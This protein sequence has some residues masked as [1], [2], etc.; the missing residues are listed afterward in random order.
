[1]ASVGRTYVSPSIISGYLAPSIHYKSVREILILAAKVVVARR[2]LESNGKPT[3]EEYLALQS[4]TD[5]VQ[6]HTHV[7]YQPLLSMPMAGHTRPL[8][9]RQHIFI[10]LVTYFCV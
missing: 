6:M 10:K 2:T 4:L 3:Q 5:V 8:T 7:A 9:P 1:M